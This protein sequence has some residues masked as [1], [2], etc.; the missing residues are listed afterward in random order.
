MVGNLFAL[1][2][3]T[4]SPQDIPKDRSNH[5]D[6]LHFKVFI[7]NAKV[8]HV[9][10]DNREGLNICTLNFVKGLG[11]FEEGVDPSYKI[12]IKAYGDFE[13]FSKGVIILPV[14]VGLTTKSTL[15]Q[16]LDIKINC[17]MILGCPWIHAMK[18]VPSTYH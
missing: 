1:Q 11:Y 16:V 15:S 3:I 14:K 4:F 5:N 12:T 6:P 2:H 17:N 18:L 8:R 7:D 10:I 9:L 13:C